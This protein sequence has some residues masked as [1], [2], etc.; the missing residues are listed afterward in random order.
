[1][2]PSSCVLG[3]P[4]LLGMI[5]Q[6][7]STKDLFCQQ[8]VSK[9]WQAVI[10]TSKTLQDRMLFRSAVRKHIDRATIGVTNIGQA[11]PA[12]WNPFMA[13]FGYPP[14]LEEGYSGCEIYAHA[15]RDLGLACAKATWKN[16][17]VTKPA[18]Q[19][20]FILRLRQGI[21]EPVETLWNDDGVTLGDLSRAYIGY[22][23]Q[24]NLMSN[25]TRAATRNFSFDIASAIGM[26]LVHASSTSDRHALI[27]GRIQ[28][29]RYGRFVGKLGDGSPIRILNNSTPGVNSGN[30]DAWHALGQLQM[31]SKMLF[32]L[33][34]LPSARL[35]WSEDAN[36]QAKS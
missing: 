15:L 19:K 8:R 28:D 5:L 34:M 20:M 4:E 32:E 25:R 9:K 31:L 16:M 24:R 22:E 35:C 12:E 13:A 11:V 30:V 26:Y 27:H 23:S 18:L 3:I 14:R 36:H 21:T 7:G 10:Q 6:Y 33:A 29:M 2:S 1:M 17:L